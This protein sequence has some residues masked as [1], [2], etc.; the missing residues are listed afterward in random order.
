[1]RDQVSLQREYY[2]RTAENYDAWHNTHL[3]EHEFALMWLSALIER[4]DIKSVLDIGS[5]T[6]RALTQLSARHPDTSFVGIEPSADLRDVAYRNG[7]PREMLI[8][9]DAQKLQFP[10]GAFE[11]VVEFG[12]LHHIPRPA[13]AVAEMLRVASRGIFIFVSNN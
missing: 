13:S 2:R 8:D 7:V 5:G 9:G 10:S 6:G 1:M 3:D 11:L 4:F 12:A